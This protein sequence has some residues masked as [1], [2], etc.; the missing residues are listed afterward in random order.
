MSLLQ[1]ILAKLPPTAE[2]TEGRRP[3]GHEAVCGPVETANAR[4]DSLPCCPNDLSC[5]ANWYRENLQVCNDAMLHYEWAWL[6]G[7]IDALER[8]LVQESLGMTDDRILLQRCEQMLR[9]SQLFRTLLIEEFSSR[10]LHHSPP[11]AEVV[12]SEEAW[13]I[14]SQKVKQDWGIL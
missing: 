13:E 8:F 5:C 14:T 12:A 2:R 6:H 9:E 11:P 4:A 10:G 1:P 7:R 3:S